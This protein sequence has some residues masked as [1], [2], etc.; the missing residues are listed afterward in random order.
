MSCRSDST[1]YSL[2][3]SGFLEEELKLGLA[4]PRRMRL[5]TDSATGSTAL[6]DIESDPFLSG[7]LMP[8]ELVTSNLRIGLFRFTLAPEQPLAVPAVNK[9]NMLRGASAMHFDGCVASLSAKTPRLA[10]WRLRAPTRL[11]LSPHRHPMLIDSQRI[12]MSHARL[13][14]VRRKR[15]RL[16]LRRA[17]TSSSALC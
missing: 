12:K 14:S 4:A 3:L 11:F 9:G 10:R 8:D 16:G 17:K 5:A 13:S 2:S 6:S 1:P 15:N 7:S